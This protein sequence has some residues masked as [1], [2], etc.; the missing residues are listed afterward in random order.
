[1]GLGQFELGANPVGSCHQQ[2]FAQARRQPAEAAEAAQAA[3]HLGATGGFN[4]GADAFDKGPSRHHVH[5]GCAVVHSRAAVG[6]ILQRRAAPLGSPGGPG[7][8]MAGGQL[9][10][11]PPLRSAWLMGVIGLTDP[12]VVDVA[13]RTQ[14][15]PWIR[16]LIVNADQSLWRKFDQKP[17]ANRV[18]F[19]G[20]SIPDRN[21]AGSSKQLLS[22]I[23]VLNT[24][25]TGHNFVCGCCFLA[26]S[27][28]CYAP[29]HPP[30][31]LCPPDFR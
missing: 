3:E 11:W 28:A 15:G 13:A 21:S 22:H 18:N 23:A 1:M 10:D 26:A 19:A 2:G 31:R 7:R 14:L 20:S 29:I 27:F 12:W 8:A 5:A 9:A 4:A 16:V 30:E 6:T 25:L 24:S 17:K